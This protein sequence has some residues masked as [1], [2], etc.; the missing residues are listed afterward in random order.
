MMNKALLLGET[1]IARE[2]LTG[3]ARDGLGKRIQGMNQDQ[4]RS[5]AHRWRDLQ[6]LQ[7]QGDKAW[8]RV[9]DTSGNRFRV[10]FRRMDT[11]WRISAL[12]FLPYPNSSD[13]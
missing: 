1:E 8:A 2:C 10:E 4:G 7:E 13:N 11:R 3:K 5:F 9:E 12:T 6:D